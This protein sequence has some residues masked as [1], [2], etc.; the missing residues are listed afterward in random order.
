[1]ICSWCLSVLIQIRVFLDDARAR[2]MSLAIE[3]DALREIL[4]VRLVKATEI[5][6]SL[7]SIKVRTVDFDER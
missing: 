4:V 7:L 5:D 6:S 3:P 1:M 2:M